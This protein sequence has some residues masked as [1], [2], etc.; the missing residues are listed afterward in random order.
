MISSFF[1]LFIFSIH[2]LKHLTSV[3]FSCKNIVMKKILIGALIFPFLC[4]A[5]NSLEFE[6]VKTEE[7]PGFFAVTIF[8]VQDEELISK[9]ITFIKN[10]SI[11]EISVYKPVIQF[12][13]EIGAKVVDSI[14]VENASTNIVSLGD[15]IPRSKNFHL[16]SEEIPL[17]QFENFSLHNLRPIFFRNLQAKF[18]GNISG[19]STL[20]KS[21]TNDPGIA[22]LGKFEKNIRTRMVILSDDNNEIVQ[23]EAPLD[24]TDSQF[25]LSPLAKQLPSLWE[26]LHH[27][28]INNSS[29]Y[30]SLFPWILGGIILFILFVIFIRYTRRKYRNFLERQENIHEELPWKTV[31]SQDNNSS[32]NPFEVE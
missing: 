30:F 15:S 31:S 16:E 12:L 18:G 9:D 7:T 26:Q 32:N 24:L 19:V 3:S 20:E 1:M 2:P 22:F 28:K 27:K 4:L 21:I 23:F 14:P 6:L 17:E 13:N 8:P 29:N 5:S 10:F 11:E 25:S